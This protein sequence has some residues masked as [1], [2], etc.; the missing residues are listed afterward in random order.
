MCAKKQTLRLQ[1]G[2]FSHAAVRYFP[3]WRKYSN[4]PC[5]NL[6]ESPLLQIELSLKN[7]QRTGR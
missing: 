5:E 7:G 3:G 1:R 6:Q 2:P 4:V